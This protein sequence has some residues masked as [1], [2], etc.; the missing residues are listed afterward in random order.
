MMSEMG[1]T[2]T[3]AHRRGMSVLPPGA[4]MSMTGR[5]APGADVGAKSVFDQACVISDT[6]RPFESHY[7]SVF[8]LD[9]GAP[10]QMAGPFS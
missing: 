1:Q 4:D 9:W 3:R 5:F 7:L 8:S 2:E 10:P 6:Q